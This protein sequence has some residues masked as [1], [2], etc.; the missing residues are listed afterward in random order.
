MRTTLA[1]AILAMAVA[2][3]AAAAAGSEAQDLRSR[4]PKNPFAF[5]P[6]QCYTRTQDADGTVHNLCYACH[7]N[8]AAPNYVDDGDLQTLYDFPEPALV[9]HW[10]NLFVD[11]RPTIA[12]QT[13]AEILRYVRADNYHDLKGEPALLDRLAQ[14]PA[15]WNINGDRVWSGYRPDVYFR[16]DGAGYDLDPDGRRDGW[17]AYG[18]M[19]LPG[20]FW[21]ANGSADDVLIR[22]PA[23]FREREDGG[24]DWTVYETNLAIVEAL[25]KREDVPLPPTDERPLGVDLDRDGKLATRAASPTPSIRATGST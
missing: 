8:S 3:T 17:R 18:Y 9:N 20:A 14:P 22:L 19:P 13:D 10:T 15:G 1:A 16:F 7:V 21:P 24:A 6:P 2:G 23:A 5:I 11:R 25:V 4:V 12:G